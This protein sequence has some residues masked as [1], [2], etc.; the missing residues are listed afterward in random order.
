MLTVGQSVGGYRIVRQL[1][2]GGMGMV[3]EALHEQ[4]GKRAAI[5]TLHQ[6]LSQQSDIATRFLN[7]VSEKFC[8]RRNH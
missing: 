7:G 1:G 6:A 5:K 8:R 3:F 2:E 4:I